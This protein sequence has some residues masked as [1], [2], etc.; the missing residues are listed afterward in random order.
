VESYA[1][2]ARP[3]RGIEP[4]AVAV[5]EPTRVRV[6]DGDRYRKACTVASGSP[7]RGQLE[8]RVGTVVDLV[9]PAATVD[10]P[11]L[12]GSERTDPHAV[13]DAYEPAYRRVLE[14]AG[15]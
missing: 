2:V 1:D 6:F 9:E 12:S 8:E 3:V 5:V 7:F 14:T 13:A 15:W 4:D 10:L 11:P